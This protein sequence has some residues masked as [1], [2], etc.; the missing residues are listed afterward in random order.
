MFDSFIQM[1]LSS[2]NYSL[3]HQSAPNTPSGEYDGI[4]ALEKEKV[5]WAWKLKRKL[6]CTEA[7]YEWCNTLSN[8][9]TLYTLT[10]VYIFS[11]YLSL[12]I[13]QG[14][15]KENFF[16]NQELFCWWSFP[17]FLQLKRMILGW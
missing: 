11:V 3:H 8:K 13:S 12:Y 7:L 2:Q 5:S 10:S 6:K 9:L 14:A 1:F 16:N 4:T 15:D 17:V